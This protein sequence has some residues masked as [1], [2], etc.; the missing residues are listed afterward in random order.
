MMSAMR[1]APHAWPMARGALRTL[2]GSVAAEPTR[3]D[4]GWS[5]RRGLAREKE[6]QLADAAK[7]Y[8]EA[9]VLEPD[10]VR[11]RYNLGRVMYEQQQ[12][13]EAALLAHGK[14]QHPSARSLQ[15]ADHF[16]ACDELAHLH[17]REL[18]RVNQELG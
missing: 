10:N 6:G 14:D 7:A 2:A 8:Q 5:M 4:G 9:R 13:P 15:H 3:A 18:P 16:L 1:L 12:L 17:V 11:I